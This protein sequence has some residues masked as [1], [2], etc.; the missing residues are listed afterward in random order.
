MH[1]DA[2]PPRYLGLGALLR[3]LRDASI[4]DN[5]VREKDTFVCQLISCKSHGHLQ[6]SL[7]AVDSVVASLLGIQ[8]GRLP[9][10]PSPSISFSDF[11]AT[12]LQLAPKVFPSASAEGALTFLLENHFAA[13]I[14]PSSQDLDF[15]YEGSCLQLLRNYDKPLTQLFVCYA[16]VDD[17]DDEYE[18]ATPRAGPSADKMRQAAATP[19]PHSPGGFASSPVKS[20]TANGSSLLK[21]EFRQQA[22]LIKT[23]K[24]LDNRGLEKHVPVT[25]R[26]LWTRDALVLFQD[27][28]IVGTQP[29]LITVATFQQLFDKAC[30]QDPASLFTKGLSF[31]EFQLLLCK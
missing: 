15:L 30:K 9:F 31:P 22:P 18:E 24:T 5:E 25:G 8:P 17:G 29:P 6:V 3:L 16:C 7:T 14:R 1:P 21:G 26:F 13:G 11:C 27:L 4:L 2:D 19:L 12:L 28:G 20:Q 10:A 23:M